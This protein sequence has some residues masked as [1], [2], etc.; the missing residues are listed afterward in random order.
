MN[1]KT[2][3]SVIAAPVRA[4][5]M[6][7]I[8]AAEQEHGIRVLYAVESGSRA[9]GFA[10]PNSDYDVRFVYA[11]EPQWYMRIDVEEQRDVIEYPIVDEIDINGWDIRKALKLFRKSNPAIVEWLKSPLV[12]LEEG[13]FAR[14]LSALLSDWYAIDKGQYHYLHMAK[15]NYRGYLKKDVVPLKKYFYVL[16]PLLAI[17]WLDKYREA[18]PIEFSRLIELIDDQSVLEEVTQL[19][20]KKKRSQEKDYIHQVQPLNRYIEK[21]LADAETSIGRQEKRAGNVDELNRIF[22]QVV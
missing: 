5:I 16:R 13:C 2:D 15:G 4:E 1:K 9:W 21:L 22:T 18:A 11:R 6:R 10:S 7:R 12:Y 3:L 17:Q 19:L 8:R 20:A 14:Q